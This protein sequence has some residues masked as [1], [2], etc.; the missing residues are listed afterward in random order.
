MNSHW[1]CHG[2][3]FLYIFISFIVLIAIYLTVFELL[4]H[5]FHFSLNSEINK[6]TVNSSIWRYLLHQKYIAFI[7]L[8]LLTIHEKRHLLD[9]KRVLNKTAILWITF[10]SL[11]FFIL[12]VFF[13]K[14]VKIIA[15]LGMALNG[16]FLL[17]TFNFL[18]AFQFFHTL[19]F[20]H[21]S[22]V[23]LKDSLLIECF[24]LLYFQEFL[25]FFL[26]LTSLIFFIFLKIRLKFINIIQE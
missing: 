13:R 8:D 15:L 24:P 1:H 11:S 3:I 7:D 2:K 14:I 21:Q 5:H 19:F 26:L 20:R 10:S 4:L 25:A 6:P 23:F 22:W 17:L 9:V 12:I 16:L 18:N